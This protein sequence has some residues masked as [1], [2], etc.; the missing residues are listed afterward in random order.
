MYLFYKYTY[1]S[2]HIGIILVLIYF[3]VVEVDIFVVDLKES[4]LQY[5]CTIL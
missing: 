5:V 3:N 4:C 2:Y 1:S